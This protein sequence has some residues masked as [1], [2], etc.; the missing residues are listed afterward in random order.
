MAA[1]SIRNPAMNDILWTP[2]PARVAAS[3]MARFRRLAEAETGFSL[4]DWPALWR[5]SI[6]DRAAFWRLLWRFCGVIASRPADEVLQEGADM[7]QARWFTG[8]RL[9]YAEN[10]LR[11]RDA[12]EAIV[13]WRE[14]GRR[15]AMTFA[16]LY[17]TTARL[18][19]WL[20]ARGVAP[21][22]RVAGFMPN[23]PETVAAMLATASLGAL[24]SSCS[25]DF[26]A[27]GV[28]DRFGQIAPKVLF[29]ADGYRYGGKPFD[30]RQRIAAIAAGLP[31]LK[32]L[33]VVAY[34]GASPDL[35][36]LADLPGLPTATPWQQALATPAEAIAFAQLPFAHPLFVMYSSGTTGAPKCIV[37]GHGGTLLQ[38][39]KEHR[40]HCDL[41]PGER[42]LYLSTCGWM[43]WNWQLSALASG[44]T[45]LLWE[46]NPFHPSPLA[47]WDFC[48]QERISV[49][50]ASAKYLQA[51]EKAGARPAESHDL[52]RL[53]LLMSTGSPLAPEGFDYVYRCIKQDVQ[54]ASISGGT[55]II[56]C[57]ALGN[58][59][60]P[61]RR[62]ELQAPGLAM[63]VEIFGED[64]RPLPPGHTG[65]LVAT[66]A[67][68]SMP[69]GF[70]NDP[71]GRAYRNA[72]FTA[73]PGVW[74]HG[75]WASVTPS[76]GMAVHGRSDAVLNPGG[77]RIGTAE[78]YRQV[79]RFDRVL[80]ALAIAQEW[81]GDVR[82]VL[83][84]VMREGH[85]LDE[86]LAAAIRQAIRANAS[87]RHVPARIVA[88]ADLPRT[89]S[90]KISELAVRD[91]VHGRQVKNTAALA[92][93]EALALFRNL[94][95]L[96]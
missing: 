57:F 81:Q 32:A 95:Q 13:C 8:A 88:V 41:R 64:G 10:L 1:A 17:H 45:L 23:L 15:T 76:G 74:R 87:P 19:A 38:H 84:V 54:L 63:A 7:T 3:Q 50:G 39:L 72:Y 16:E 37:H 20:R 90:G 75:D 31:G 58:P 85:A 11:R 9:N 28:L 65:E 27:D 26:G 86:P 82:V 33:V 47:L 14:D 92:N 80:E 51:L 5:W 53:R 62:G 70:W 34:G 68:P 93:P 36:D 40:L 25:P 46:G 71:Q 59:L 89:R 91:V 67:F 49:F 2:H 83:F 60:L 66:R 77:V 12:C 94:P 96:A 69:T 4:P 22:D 52:S 61:V 35:T 42:L 79:E 78:L 18:A 48:Q 44:A 73:F 24:W 29:A 6:A 55:D 43:M 21:G 30:S 56:S